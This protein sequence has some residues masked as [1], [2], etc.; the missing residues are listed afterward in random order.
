MS[1]LPR[2]AYTPFT[3]TVNI[4]VFVSNI[5]ET[6]FFWMN[7]FIGR[8]A[9]QSIRSVKGSIP[10]GTMLNLNGDFNV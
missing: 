5:L 6:F 1:L 9:V 4:T 3:C 8:I 2:K 10:I 7:T